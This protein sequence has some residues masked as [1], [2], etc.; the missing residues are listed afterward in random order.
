MSIDLNFQM[1]FVGFQV[2]QCQQKKKMEQL[3]GMVSLQTS[4]IEKKWKSKFDSMPS[5]TI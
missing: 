2:M 4:Q 5:M 3:F 1:G